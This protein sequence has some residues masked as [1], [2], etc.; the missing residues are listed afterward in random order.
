MELQSLHAFS[1]S[2]SLLHVLHLAALSF[3]S[4]KIVSDGRSLFDAA[5][6]DTDQDGNLYIL[7]LFW[8]T[9]AGE[10]RIMLASRFICGYMSGVDAW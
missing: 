9:R 2:P 7:W 1:L 8:E 10:F 3:G 5:L 4:M 6:T